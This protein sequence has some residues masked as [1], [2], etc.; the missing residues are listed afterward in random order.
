[1]KRAL[2]SGITG[3]AGSYLAELLLSKGYEVHGIVRRSSTM[4]GR[5]R[6]TDC[7]DQITLHFGDIIEGVRMAQIIHEVQPDEVYHLA[8]QSH[9]AVSFDQAS[10][11]TQS[12]V[13]GTTNML[14]AV[15]HF[16]P[17]AR[18]YQASSSEMYGITPPMQNETAPMLPRSPYACAKLAAYHS[19]RNYREAYGIHASNGILFNHE[20]PRRGETFVTQKIV[21]AAKAIKAGTQSGLVLGDCSAKRDWGHAKDYVRAMWLMLQQDAGDDYVVATGEQHSIRDFID[22]VFAKVFRA[23]W[24]DVTRSCVTYDDPA[25]QRPL[26]VPSLC[27]DASKARRVLGW[28]PTIDFNG[29]IEDMVR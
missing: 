26:D 8:A 9:V 2:L 16:A 7:I 19:V 21:R 23:N 6:L 11:T 15:R 22:V 28:E 24:H 5:W 14:E 27:G 1:M 20:S 13:V 17:Q 18:F 25:F 10:Y 4:A 12:I 3:Q 29:L